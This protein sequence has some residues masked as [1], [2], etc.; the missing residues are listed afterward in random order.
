MASS[1]YVRATGV[2]FSDS[3]KYLVLEVIL[4]LLKLY[5]NH[6]SELAGRRNRELIEKILILVVDDNPTVLRSTCKILNNAGYETIEAM[7]GRDALRLAKDLRPDLALLDVMLPDIN[8][9]EVCQLIKADVNSAQTYVVLISSIR[10]HHE[11]QALGLEFGADGYIARPVS[12]REL[13]AR[14]ESLLR[15]RRT[16][17]KLRESQEQLALAIEGS[18]VG[19]WDWRVQT[20]QTIFNERWAQMIGYTL[21]EL[22]P[23]DINTWRKFAHP[24]DLPKSEA[25]IQ[26]LFA[27]QTQAYECEVRMKHKDGHWVWILDRGKVTEWDEAGKP[28]RMTGTHL[29]ISERKFAELELLRYREDLEEMVREQ[30]ADLCDSE[31]KYRTVADYTYDWEYWI[32]PDGNIPY[33]APSCERI[34]GYK[35]D[36]FTDDPGLLRDIIHPE[37]RST[38]GDHFDMIDCREPHT[39]D[40]RIV[41]RSG[42]ERWIEHRCQ[43][44]FDASHKCLGR[45]VSNRD[46]TSRKR[47]EE[48]LRRSE[49]KFSKVFHCAPALMT[50][51]NS[52]DA[53]LIDV[54]DAFCESS[55][56]SREECIGKTSLEIGWLSP[57][58]RSR[59]V[60]E[61]KAHGSVRG[62]DLKT[63]TRDKKEMELLFSGEFLETSGRQLLL[64][65]ALDITE[66]KRVEQQRQRLF[67]VVEQ[68]SEGILITDTEGIIQYVNPAE[69]IISGYSSSELIGRSFDVF[70][71]DLNNENFIEDMWE[72]IRSG[73]LWSGKFINRKKDGTEYHEQNNISPVYDESGNLT[74]FVAIKHDV[75]GQLALEK[76]LLHSQKMEAVGTLASGIAHDFN[77]ILQVVLGHAE[78]LADDDEMP[79]RLKEQLG[80]LTRATLNGAELVKRLMLFSRKVETNPR[81]LDINEQILQIKKLLYRT[82]H[83]N[84]EIEIVSTKEIDPIKAD[85]VQ[86]EQIIMNLVLNARDA[87]PLG[88]KI[89][90]E[91]GNVSLDSTF[92]AHHVG[93]SPGRYVLLKISD[94]GSGIPED[95]LP[96]IFE[97]FFTTKAPGYGTGLGLSTVL[98]I[99]N[100]QEGIITCESKQGLGTTFYVYLP[101]IDSPQ[102]HVKAPEQSKPAG[103]S[104]TILVVDDEEFVRNVEESILRSAG[105]QV[106]TASDGFEAWEIYKA[107]HDSIRLTILDI[108]MPRMDGFEC[109]KRIFEINPKARILTCSGLTQG[110]E[111]EK[112]LGQGSSGHIHKPAKKNVL[113][114]KVRKI[115]DQD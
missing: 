44:V 80:T 2:S 64:A 55:G 111:P 84:I 57:E 37:D 83:K 61:F 47:Y 68:V 88:G 28:L 33:M 76:Q 91:T 11:Y 16:E 25:L 4:C 90:V 113:L 97:P 107:K 12:N 105:Y 24:E 13:L 60:G 10:T 115:L 40:F 108:V 101:V 98:W 65:T 36:E 106:V 109:M 72:T 86:I 38:V 63:H 75:T 54:N 20:G 82:I 66:R 51:S 56:F 21:E 59:L 39:V 27:C 77:N 35:A 7:T 45:R 74:N 1:T 15:L 29:D 99:V 9:D 6:E 81:P 93:V 85:P 49:E 42:D 103:G 22:A 18:G 71:S 31:L 73:R 23:I 104:E 89:T 79:L 19:L 92:C 102:V 34:T 8:G 110:T 3:P 70:H 53:T 112:L 100:S 46:I 5:S 114:E 14:V 32:A 69:E 95:V 48:E 96:H 43:A 50:L 58:E 62:M 30:T 41:T 78:Q 52:D 26:K 87:M 94:N 67:K 17:K